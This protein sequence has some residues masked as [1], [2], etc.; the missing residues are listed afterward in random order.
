MV[1]NFPRTRQGRIWS[2][3][4]IASIGLILLILVA[5]C[6][7][8]TGTTPI[9]SAAP[10][11]T[12]DFNASMAAA[13]AALD[14]NNITAAEQS[15]RAAVSRDPKS[16]QAQ[17]G[18]G[19]ALVRLG[20]LGEAEAAYKAALAVDPNM[21]AARANLGVVFYQMGQLAKAADESHRGTQDQ[22][23]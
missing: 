18:L 9:T 4:A 1:G 22:P 19:N 17:F 20:K 11:A 2:L 14:A 3:T 5:G 15:Y 23:E 10:T 16:A 13:S 7:A 6:T 12:G 21:T 8:N